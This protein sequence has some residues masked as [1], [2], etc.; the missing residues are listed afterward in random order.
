MHGHGD[1]LED[2]RG[3][4]LRWRVLSRLLPRFKPHLGSLALCAVLLI[5]F[6]LLSL[7]GPLLVRHAIDVNFADKDVHG[8][9]ITSGLFLLVLVLSFTFNYLQMVRLETVGQAIVKDIRIDIFAHLTRLGQSFF[10]KNPVG[11][12]L[13]RVESDTEALRTMFTYT[14]VS[15]LS[16]LIMMVGM[17]AVMLT[18][19]PRL[20]LVLFS[21]VPLVVL[22][23]RWFNKRLIPIFIA[24]R[25]KTAEVYAFLEEYMRGAKVVQ[26]FDQ[27]DNVTAHMNMVNKAKFDVEY[28]GEMLSNYFGHSIGLVSSV[29]TA[30]ILGFG[31]AWVLGRPELLSIGTL[32]AFLNYIDRFFGPILHLSEQ[33]NIIQRAFAGA[34]RILEIQSEPLPGKLPALVD[35]LP[36]AAPAQPA[37]IAFDHVWFSYKDDDWVIK[38]VSFT[39]A[40]GS[41]VAVVGPT[42]GGKTTLVSLLL[43]FYDQQRGTIRIDGVDTRTMEL[44][45]LR[46]RMGLVLQDI[47][48]FQGSLLDN[49]R[50][51]DEGIQEERVMTALETVDAAHL[52]ARHPDGL[53]A[54]LAEDGGNLSVGERQLL[55]FARALVFDPDILILDEATSSV[56]PMTERR[57]QGAVERLLAGRTAMIVAHRLETIR[58]CDDILV[59]QDGCIQERGSHDE[60]VEAGGLYHT[61]HQIQNGARRSV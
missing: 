35:E 48:L 57:V 12:L 8:L 58:A 24:A 27:E 30:L 9:L 14:V 26:A 33:F 40:R 17:L 13:S 28:P 42:G 2:V 44:T 51:G 4:K 19:S 15:I 43:R 47:V 29:A 21:L 59:V 16:D 52:A 41:R 45:D 5:T 6:S 61:L 3:K 20:A 46:R 38:D 32:V 31:G 50:L 7:A 39:I 56:D 11:Q 55:S 1:G 54:T 22:M 25:R 18:L 23:V 53:H 60:L 49:L 10:D 34:E 36:A 37:A